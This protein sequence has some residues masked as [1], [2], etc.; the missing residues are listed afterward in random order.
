MFSKS[1]LYIEDLAHISETNIE[2]EKLQNKTVLVIGA[3]G[4]IGTVLV[5]ALM[6]RNNKHKSNIKVLVMGRNET[7]IIQRFPN[8]ENNKL[9]EVITHSLLE[10]ININQKVDYII[11]L[12]SNTHPTLYATQPIN[13]IEL[14]IKGTRNVLDFAAQNNV[15]RVINLSSVEVYGE[16][17]GDVDKF[18]EDYC[19]Y[20]NCNTLRANYPEGKRLAETMC[21]AY[22]KEK[23][24]DVVTARL[25]RVY[26]PTFL[27]GDSKAITQ[28]INNAVNGEDIV[29]KSEGKQ[30]YSYIYVADVVAALLI[31]LIK[32]EKGEAY[33]I[34]NDEI[35]TL[36]EIAGVLAK[37]NNKEV[38]FELPNE[39]EKAGFSVVLKALMDSSKFKAL[40]W[41]AH[42]SLEN[43]LNKT[44]EI[45]RN[46]NNKKIN[47][48]I[49]Q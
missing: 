34:A 43:G 15:K 19:G 46:Y 35:I 6:Y 4:L 25:A 5:D 7:K 40:G 41:S 47:N 48:N 26:G 29:L 27:G 36:A 45:L 22:I 8:Y 16:N 23:G 30:E 11:N 49:S 10:P 2:W 20:I 18:K 37:I 24:I 33:N 39:I 32:G 31:L 42:Y 28:F 44:V 14:I 12:A 17:R 13:T 9:F 3:T 1:K 38:K 21:Q